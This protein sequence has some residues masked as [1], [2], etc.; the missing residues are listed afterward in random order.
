M[1]FFSKNPNPPKKLDNYIKKN[2][3]VKKIIVD[4]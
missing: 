3:L 4:K 2:W 1:E